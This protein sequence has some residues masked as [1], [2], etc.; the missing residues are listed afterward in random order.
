MRE[1]PWANHPPIK[2][3]GTKQV[4]KAAPSPH[5]KESEKVNRRYFVKKKKVDQAAVLR[6]RSRHFK[7]G[8]GA[9]FFV[10]R[11]RLFCWPEP[12]AKKESLCV[13][14][15]YDLRA[16]YNCKCDLK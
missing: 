13:V 9:D 4:T 16:I 14:T 1:R 10:G 5:F 7:G 2:D 15:K 3:R 6:S 11:S 8:A 12:Q